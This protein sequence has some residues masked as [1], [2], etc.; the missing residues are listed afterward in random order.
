MTSPPK[1]IQDLFSAYRLY[2]KQNTRLKNRIYSLLKEQLYGFTQ[3]E[4]FDRKSRTR[5]RTL[6]GDGVLSFQINRLPD[7]LER[8]ETDV[9]EL[10]EQVLLAAEPFMARIYGQRRGLPIPT[11]QRVSG[12]RTSGDTNRHRRRRPNRLTM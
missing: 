3:E 10:K 12:G 2:R 9:E 1:E 8:D 6:S 5:I 11:P 7:R 4:I